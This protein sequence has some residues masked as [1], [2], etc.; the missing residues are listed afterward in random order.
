MEKTNQYFNFLT[1]PWTYKCLIA[2][3]GTELNPTMI[4]LT[5]SI[6]QV[7][8]KILNA[9]VTSGILLNLWI[10]TDVVMIQK[11]PNNPKINKVRVFN[12]FEA[13]CNLVLKYYWL[14]Q[15]YQ[16]R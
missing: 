10:I 6:V 8:N 15:V 16:F 14:Y 12:K 3:D 13:D 11:E 2:S 9:S 7:D 1:P 5:L 4:Y